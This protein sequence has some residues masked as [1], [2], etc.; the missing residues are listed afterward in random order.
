M[1]KNDTDWI[2]EGTQRRAKA[3]DAH[4]SGC[5]F[6]TSFY[7]P[8]SRWIMARSCHPK[9]EA[10]ECLR[11]AEG[12]GW[13]HDAPPSRKLSGVR[14]RG[15][16]FH[17]ASGGRACMVAGEGQRFAGHGPAGCGSRR[18]AVQPGEGRPPP[19]TLGIQGASSTGWMNHRCALP[20]NRSPCAGGGG[21][22]GGC[23]GG[24][25]GLIAFGGR[26]SSRAGGAAATFGARTSGA[27]SASSEPLHGRK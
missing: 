4:R 10:Q 14:P 23:A 21:G 1:S 3:D 2:N 7:C 18:A 20:Q 13:R 25:I 8:Y 9:K 15:Q 6:T 22:E 17:L 12:Q 16:R 11:R 19:A 24:G 26:I 5:H 27:G